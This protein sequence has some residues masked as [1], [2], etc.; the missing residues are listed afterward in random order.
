MF[1]IYSPLFPNSFVKY[2]TRVVQKVLETLKTAEEF[3]FVVSSLNPGI[4][5]LMKNTNGN[6]VAQHCLRYLPLEFKEVNLII[7]MHPHDGTLLVKLT[8]VML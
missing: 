7:L 2:R 1:L 6:H 4:V 5:T 3:S 8:S